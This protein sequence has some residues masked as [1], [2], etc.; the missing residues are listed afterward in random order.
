MS[1]VSAWSIGFGA[2][3]VVDNEVGVGQ[4]P[5]VASCSIKF[6]VLLYSNILLSSIYVSNND[7]GVPAFA[8]DIEVAVPSLLELVCEPWLGFRSKPRNHPGIHGAA[9]PL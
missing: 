8:L 2:A 1:I 5:E 4:T 9:Q 3:T 6:T 7:L